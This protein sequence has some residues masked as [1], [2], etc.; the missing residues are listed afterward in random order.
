MVFFSCNASQVYFM[1]FARPYH[2][3][4]FVILTKHSFLG[5]STCLSSIQ[6]SYFFRNT[7]KKNIIKKLFFESLPPSTINEF[8]PST[9]E[10]FC[11][12][13]NKNK[14]TLAQYFCMTNFDKK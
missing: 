10:A 6:I 1:S 13:I 11:Y 3:R 14:P 4:I 12:T 9:I 2:K 8:S 7:K 5:V